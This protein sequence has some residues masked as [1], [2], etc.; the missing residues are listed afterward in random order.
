MDIDYKKY[1]SIVSDCIINIYSL[2]KE[3]KRIILT[4][5]DPNIDTDK[6]VIE[7]A[8]IAQSLWNYDIEVDLPF[9]KYLLFKIKNKKI[10]IKRYKKYTNK[11]VDVQ[12]LKQFVSHAYVETTMIFKDI[13]DEYYK[14]R[15]AD[16][17]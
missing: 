1:D 4:N 15:K 12:E 17:K 9:I 11:K 2:S 3:E 16:K 7:I 6:C 5:F 13:Y 14:P 10:N 8:K